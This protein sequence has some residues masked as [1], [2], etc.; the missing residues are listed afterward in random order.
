MCSPRHTACS[1]C[2]MR[3][4]GLRVIVAYKLV[5]AALELALGVV[6]LAM[7][8]TVT[9]E[10]LFVAHVVREHAVAAWSLLLSDRLVGF[11]TRKHVVLVGLASI[12][13]A[14]VSCVEGWSLHRRYA[15]SRWLVV[16]ATASLVPFEIAS[17]V[18]RFSIGRVLVLAFNAWVVV[19]LVRHRVGGRHG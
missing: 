5:K 3:S 7:S 6:L 9:K 17:L 10:L 16:V 4:V 1:A 12:L 2:F 11:A 13:D 19:Y 8:Q 18:R 15:W 14:A